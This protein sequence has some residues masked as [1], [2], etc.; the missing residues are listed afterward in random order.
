MA[1]S[2]QVDVKVSLDA[3]TKSLIKKLI[4]ALDRSVT[5]QKNLSDASLAQEPERVS[6]VCDCC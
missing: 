2:G 6:D 5:V 4:R 1:S 3:E